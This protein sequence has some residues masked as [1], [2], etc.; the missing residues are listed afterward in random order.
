MIGFVNTGYLTLLLVII[1]YVLGFVEVQF[2]NPID[3]GF[4]YHFR[5]I[6]R[7]R[8]TARRVSTLR[9]AVLMFSDQQLVTGIA[10]LVGGFSQ[11]RDGLDAYHW[12]ILVY[13]VWFSSLTH[14]TTLTVLRQY[15]RDNSTIRLWRAVF[16]L[17]IVVMLDI[18]LV[19]TGNSFWLTFLPPLSNPNSSWILAGIPVKC[20]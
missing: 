6:L 20:Y 18:A 4:L 2:L 9:K 3:Q 11:L 14:L 16:M 10:L 15:F 17:I 12:Q 13:L 1:Y 8:S 5:R 7:P 19:P